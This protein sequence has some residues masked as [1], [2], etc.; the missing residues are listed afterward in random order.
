M[1]ESINIVVDDTIM[2]K[3]TDVEKDVGT[4]AQQ[5]DTSEN[6]GVIELDSEPVGVE[7]DNLKQTKVPL[8]EFKKIIQSNLLSEI[9]MKGSPL[10]PDM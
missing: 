1:M 9:L 6:E 10:D 5:T 2:E 3:G 7:P 4:L 8:L